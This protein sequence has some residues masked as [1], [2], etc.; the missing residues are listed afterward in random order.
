MFGG[1]QFTVVVQMGNAGD[2]GLGNWQWN[3][4]L[5]AQHQNIFQK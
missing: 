3:W 1:K 5:K 2:L 4:E